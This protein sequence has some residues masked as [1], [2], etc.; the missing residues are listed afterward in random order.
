MTTTIKVT[1]HNYPALVEIFD[2]GEKTDYTVVTKEMGEQQF[3]CTT[4]RQLRITDLEYGTA[5]KI[6]KPKTA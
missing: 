3:Y 4:T 2:N 1:S 5:E 6:A